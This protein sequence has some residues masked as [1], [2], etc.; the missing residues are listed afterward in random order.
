MCENV[1]GIACFGVDD[2]ETMDLVLYKHLH[3]IIEA[4]MGE[5]GE[6]RGGGRRMERGGWE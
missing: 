1:E 5:G 6:G 4:G 2:R 3:C